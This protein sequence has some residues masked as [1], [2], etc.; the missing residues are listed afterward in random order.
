MNGRMEA[1]W[2]GRTARERMLV[3]VMGAA[4]AAFALWFGA[5]RP[6]ALAK[7]A[8][9]RRFDAAL[10]EQAAV[11]SAAARIRRLQAQAAAPPGAAPA[12]EAVNAS[13]AAAGLT[14]QR[15]EPDET[16]GVQVAIGGVSS[17]KLFG[18]LAALQRDYGV[19]PRHLTVIKDEAGGLSADATFGGV[20]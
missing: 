5:Y 6:V 11:R 2:T 3:A 13:A 4:I 18:W 9:E 8:A 19:T 17:V 1:W 12:A 7:A 14:L 15:I 20:E 16:G 10:E